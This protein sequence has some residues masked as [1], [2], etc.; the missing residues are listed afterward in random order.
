MQ[1]QEADHI[2]YLLE[3]IRCGYEGMVNGSGGPFGA[4]VVKNGEIISRGHNEVLISNDPTAHAEVVAIRRACESLNSF[5]L[6]GC[7]IYA[8]C[9]P[10][11]MCLGA[12]YWSRP[13]C[14]YYASGKEDATSAGFDDTFIYNE[15]N[16][17]HSKRQIPFLRYKIPEADELFAKWQK[18]ASKRLY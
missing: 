16:T 14:V 15:I 17:E 9:E 10:C 12:I 4:V 1:I 6:T 18:L 7:I 13:L 11:P 2:F 5:E 8:S 3:A